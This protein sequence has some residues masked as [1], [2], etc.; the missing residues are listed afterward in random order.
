MHP[1]CPAMWANVTCTMENKDNS[2]SF[3]VGAG[4]CSWIPLKHYSQI[5]RWKI[6][7]MHR[8]T[9][10]CRHP[11]KRHLHK[12]LTSNTQRRYEHTQCFFHSQEFSSGISIFPVHFP[13]QWKTY[14]CQRCKWDFLPLITNRN[15]APIAS[16][17]QSN[18]P[19]ETS[20][21]PNPILV[22]EPCETTDGPTAEA[23]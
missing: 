10:I 12:A 18:P 20:Y 5:L 13:S 2:N 15:P 4:R 9:F 3:P 22:Q 7:Q 16:H 6:L 23:A 8:L 17:L 1:D 19:A 21:R 14:S 11:F